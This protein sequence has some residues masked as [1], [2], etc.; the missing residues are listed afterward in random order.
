[1]INNRWTP[2]M[3]AARGGTDDLTHLY[4][5]ERTGEARLHAT[6]GP[7]HR[8]NCVRIRQSVP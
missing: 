3:P 5:L 6:K 7:A 1:M 8:G 2:V 4:D